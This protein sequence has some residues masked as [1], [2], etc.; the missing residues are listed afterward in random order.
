MTGFTKDD[1][2][3]DIMDVVF[4]MWTRTVL[5]DGGGGLRAPRPIDVTAAMADVKWHTSRGEEPKTAIP[6]SL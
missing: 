6:M 3:R 2:S 4:N 1:A 5:F